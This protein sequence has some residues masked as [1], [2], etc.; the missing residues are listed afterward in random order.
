LWDNG[1]VPITLQR[2]EALGLDDQVPP[3]DT[4]SDRL[5]S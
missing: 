4:A 5:P 1:N 2:W 3:L